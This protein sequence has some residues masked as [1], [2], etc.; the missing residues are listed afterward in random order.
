MNPRRTTLNA[1]LCTAAAVSVCA[2]LAGCSTHAD[3]NPITSV[4]PTGTATN[5]GT[6]ATPSSSTSTSLD[7]AA[8]ETRDRQDAEVVW[9]K[10]DTLLTTVQSLP[11]DQVTSALTAVAIDPALSRIQ[12]QNAQF[13]AEGKVG[14]GTDIIYVSWPKSINGGD[15]AVLDDCQDGSQ[16]GVK[17]AKTGNKLTVGTPNTPIEV[18]LK[19]TEQGWKVSQADLIAGGTCT[20]GKAW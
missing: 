1:A 6:S 11:A 20:P 18:T 5:G 15:T 17:D 10:F 14:Y 3:A 12:A 7:A 4:N 8:Q 13:R 9:R 2:A 16:S 19:R